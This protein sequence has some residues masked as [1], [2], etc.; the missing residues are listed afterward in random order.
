LFE[1]SFHPALRVAHRAPGAA[2]ITQ[3]QAELNGTILVTGMTAVGQY[4]AST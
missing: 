1:P 2:F 4:T 3:L